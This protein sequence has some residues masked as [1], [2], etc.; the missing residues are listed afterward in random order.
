M[1][2][3]STDKSLR[4]SEISILAVLET[5]VSVAVAILVTVWTESGWPLLFWSVSG[6]ALLMRTDI[7]INRGITMLTWLYHVSDGPKI[8][9]AQ[10]SAWHSKNV[11][12]MS[13]LSNLAS[14]RSSLLP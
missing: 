10:R 9:E 3:H 13:A 7:S 1:R 6:W 11:G 4:N 5:I 14:L 12:W 8:A 2:W